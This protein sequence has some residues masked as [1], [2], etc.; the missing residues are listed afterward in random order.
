MSVAS[1]I[2]RRFDVDDLKTL[3]LISFGS[4]WIGL[5]T[6]FLTGK[7]LEPKE[8]V[9]VVRTDPATGCQ[10]LEGSWGQLTLRVDA[11]GKPICS[12]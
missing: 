9:P 12:R 7:A 8:W 11:S 6:M 4:L 1:A 10:Y 2:R 3:G 5:G